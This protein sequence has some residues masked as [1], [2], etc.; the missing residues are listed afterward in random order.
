M[1][2]DKRLW[3]T[4]PIDF[5]DHPKIRPLSDGA[6]RAFVEMNAYSRVQD[7]DGK[8]PVKVARLKWKVKYL[9]E[10]ETNHDVR[11]TLSIVGEDY[12][13][14][15]YGEHQQTKADREA[16]A[17]KN[18]ANGAKGGRPPKGKPNETQSV[19]DS[20]A[21]Q[22]Q[23]QSQSQSQ[24]S[25]S[26]NYLTDNGDDTESS[27][28][29]NRASNGP[30]WNEIVSAKAKKAGIRHPQAVWNS[31]AGVVEG[32]LTA[33]AVVALVAGITRK[34]PNPIRDVDAYIAVVCRT[35]ADEVRTEYERLDL[36]A[37]V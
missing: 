17:A 22:K 23:S 30:D 11:P 8:I 21:K 24:S 18:S 5:P 12:V 14:H 26:E 28:V 33:Q 25:E 16:L 1:P 31:L 10:L 37:A 35:S 34:S 32:P 27:H 2:T 36:A 15:N 29:P 13:L 3:M 4:F 19:S 7:L 20:L 9:R 6:F